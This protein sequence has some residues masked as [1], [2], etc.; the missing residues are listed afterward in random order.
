[1]I[2]VDTFLLDFN[3]ATKSR[4][5]LKNEM[6]EYLDLLDNNKRTAALE[7]SMRRNITDLSIYIDQLNQTLG[8]S[9][10][11]SI[12]N[13][14]PE[15]VTK[16]KG[17]VDALTNDLNTIEQKL[18]ELLHDEPHRALPTHEV[19]ANFRTPAASNMS[20]SQILLE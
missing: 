20:S 4:N 7:Y 13:I 16:R 10:Y 6:T 3:N 15:E 1:M 2:G 5:S 9:E 17:Q 8:S 18:N 19:I 12:F 14:S 11:A